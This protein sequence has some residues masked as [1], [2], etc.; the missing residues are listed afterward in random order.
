MKYHHTQYGI[1][2]IA[3]VGIVIAAILVRFLINESINPVEAGVAILLLITLFLFAS[4]TV[5]ISHGRVVCRFGPG[6]IRKEI[7]LSDVTDAR[8]V[9]NSWIAGWGIRWM[10]GR[11]MLWNVSGF[12]AVELTLTNG[13]RFRIGTNEPNSLVRAIQINKTVSPKSAAPE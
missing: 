4:L 5:E 11:Y 1:V 6:L 2:I 13:K 10:P 8:P 3:A 12:Q 9:K 7:K